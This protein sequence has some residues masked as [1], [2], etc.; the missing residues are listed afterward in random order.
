MQGTN[1]GETITLLEQEHNNDVSVW[2]N[3]DKKLSNSDYKDVDND[4]VNEYNSNSIANDETLVILD[5]LRDVTSRALHL[6]SRLRDSHLEKKKSILSTD[7]DEVITIG[8]AHV[9]KEM[10]LA[11]DNL[12]WRLQQ[13]QRGLKASQL[14]ITGLKQA[15]IESEDQLDKEKLNSKILQEEVLSMKS[16]N[17]K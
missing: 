16:Q 2:A 7:G 12:R 13:R 5:R 6:E 15:L 14:I 1:R 4:Y 11:N 3:L 10:K 8:Q 9:L 17:N